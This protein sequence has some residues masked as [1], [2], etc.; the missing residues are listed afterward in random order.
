MQNADE[1]NRDP[2]TDDDKDG[3]RERPGDLKDDGS[4]R[5]R[6]RD[7]GWDPDDRSSEGGT[8][9]GKDPAEREGS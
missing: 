3:I 4:T 5:E 9:E 7:R 1:R 2:G 6:R 8:G